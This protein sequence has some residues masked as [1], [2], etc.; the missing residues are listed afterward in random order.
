VVAE[1]HVSP[2][3]RPISCTL[4]RARLQSLCSE[5]AAIRYILKKGPI[6]LV[7]HELLDQLGEKCE[8]LWEAAT[9]RLSHDELETEDGQVELLIMDQCPIG[10]PF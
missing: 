10:K 8:L 7:Q 9:A 6:T 3:P 2:D 4:N 5:I 1:P